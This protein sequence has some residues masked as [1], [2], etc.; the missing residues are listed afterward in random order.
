MESGLS[1]VLS[2]V[3]VLGFVIQRESRREREIGNILVDKSHSPSLIL[4]TRKEM[5]RNG[6]DGHAC[7]PTEQYYREAFD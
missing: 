3:Q 7:T 6:S 2:R 5:K 1:G 4:R